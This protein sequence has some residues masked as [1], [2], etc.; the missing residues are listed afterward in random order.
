MDSDYV[1]NCFQSVSDLKPRRER[2][3]HIRNKGC[4]KSEE[5]NCGEKRTYF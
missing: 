5:G 3:D 1:L 2:L 4:R